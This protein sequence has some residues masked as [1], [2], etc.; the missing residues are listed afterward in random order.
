L[1]DDR[2][3]RYPGTVSASPTPADDHISSP[4]I[5]LR[6][7]R[8]RRT[9]PGSRAIVGGILVAAAVLG[10]YAAS[11]Q[12]A[13]ADMQ[14]VV[15]ATRDIAPGTRLQPGDVRTVKMQI[16]SALADRIVQSTSKLS[17]ATSLAPLRS[18]DVIQSS[19]IAAA[20]SS[21]PYL[22]VS[23]SLPASRALDGSLRPGETVDILVTDKSVPSAVA[24]AAVSNAQVLRTQAGNGGMGQSEDLTITVGVKSR[25]EA[26]AVAAAIDHGQVTLLRTTGVSANG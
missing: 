12:S 6:L 10:T 9:L 23:F 4:A 2:A 17:G 22:E 21:T 24:H 20:S 15:V 1:A 13:K 16:D 26:A 5:N 25:S 14:T 8:P 7:I 19:G 18:G 3:T 11:T